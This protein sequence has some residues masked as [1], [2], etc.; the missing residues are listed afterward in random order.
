MV[1]ASDLTRL[2]EDGF[3]A[4]DS[5]F[6][7]EDVREARELLDPLFD[8]FPALPS[9]VAQDLGATDG[10]TA[11]SR[12]P[13]INRPTL[14][15]PLLRE[16]SIFRKCRSVARRLGG[17]TARY[18]FDHAIYKAPQNETPTP[19][20]QDQAYN[21]HRKVLKTLHFWI[22][23]QDASVDN[24][25]M[26]FVPGSHRA[27]VLDHSRRDGKA[28]LEVE[29][30]TWPQ[31]IACPIPAG[32]ATIHT[33]LTL[34]YTGPNRSDDVRRAWIIHFGPWGRLAKLHPSV[35]LDKFVL[36]R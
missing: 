23:L 31:D 30:A 2:A 9:S 36:R 19:W 24:G 35:L 10:S 6:T 7:A 20:H 26:H 4:L 33:P 1:T 16:S 5:L 15:Q 11:V 13:E 25:C 14:L 21:G 28:V 34:H 12:S 29:E 18:T 32:G 8:R 27:G 17:R 3:L 22:P